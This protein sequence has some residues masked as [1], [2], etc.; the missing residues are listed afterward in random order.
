MPSHHDVAVQLLDVPQLPEAATGEELF[1]AVRVHAMYDPSLAPHVARF[2]L[3]MLE[4]HITTVGALGAAARIANSWNFL[5]DKHPR[6][7]RAAVLI[8]RAL[9]DPTVPL[10][11]PFYSTIGSIA[12]SIINSLWSE[13]PMTIS[14]VC[15]ILVMRAPIP[16]TWDPRSITAAVIFVLVIVLYATTRLLL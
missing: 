12:S 1:E 3:Y 16:T 9:A 5:M 4:K 2:R 15:T 6:L 11:E 10:H 8:I 14:S 7:P 13:D